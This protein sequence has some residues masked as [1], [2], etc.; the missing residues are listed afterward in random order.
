MENA[1][2]LPY[3]GVHA[4]SLYAGLA[5]FAIAPLLIHLLFLKE[6]PENQNGPNYYGA[7]LTA[8]I[9]AALGS[10]VKILSYMEHENDGLIACYVVGHLLVQFALVV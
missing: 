10:M 8:T 2:A 1:F 7:R 5:M 6:V 9:A 4:I 3:I